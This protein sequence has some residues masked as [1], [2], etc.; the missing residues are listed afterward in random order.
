LTDDVG[1]FSEY[2]FLRIVSLDFS[3]VNTPSDDEY[4]AHTL[5][6]GVRW[7]FWSSPP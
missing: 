1:L 7:A 2:R 4:A 3:M 5:L 6:V